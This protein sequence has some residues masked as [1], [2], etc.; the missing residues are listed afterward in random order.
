M[1]LGQRQPRPDHPLAPARPDCLAAEETATPISSAAGCVRELVESTPS[2]PCVR[3][4][5]SSRP[6]IHERAVLIYTS[7]NPL[8]SAHYIHTPFD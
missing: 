6:L 7:A 4:G 5:S 2:M 1:A 8:N 3:G